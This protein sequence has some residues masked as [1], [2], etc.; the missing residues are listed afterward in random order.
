MYELT[1]FRIVSI[2][3]SVVGSLPISLVYNMIE[4]QV[5]PFHQALHYQ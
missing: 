5:E 1:K 3:R 4:K 2:C